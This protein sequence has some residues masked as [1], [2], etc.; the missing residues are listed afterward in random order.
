MSFDSFDVDD[1]P[2]VL[3]RLWVETFNDAAQFCGRFEITTGIIDRQSGKSRIQQI[4]AIGHQGVAVDVVQTC[5]EEVETADQLFVDVRETGFDPHEEGPAEVVDVFGRAGQLPHLPRA[6]LFGRVVGGIPEDFLEHFVVLL[7]DD[8]AD[9]EIAFQ[10]D[11]FPAQL[12]RQVGHVG[13]FAR[14]VEKV[15]HADVA[16]PPQLGETDAVALDNAHLTHRGHRTVAARHVE[17]AAQPMH[18]VTL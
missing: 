17:S 13:P 14:L 12:F 2:L 15:Q 16:L 10:A 6:R 5:E 1:G 7:E 3:I 11:E 18:P 8:R 4:P 9:F